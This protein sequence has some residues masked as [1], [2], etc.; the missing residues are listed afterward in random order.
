MHTS[1]VIDSEDRPH[2]GYVRKLEGSSEL[3]YAYRDDEDWVI[4]TVTTIGPYIPGNAWK[5]WSA[6][7]SLSLD[8][9]DQPHMS[10]HDS[11]RHALYYA[12]RD[13]TGWISQAIVDT[14]DSNPTKPMYNSLTLDSDGRPYISFYDIQTGDLKHAYLTENVMY[15]PLILPA[16]K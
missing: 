3:K 7:L 4:E 16:R 14:G 5:P 13:E 15:L 6:L 8:D 1:L 12:R 2:I 9:M 11:R 10:Y